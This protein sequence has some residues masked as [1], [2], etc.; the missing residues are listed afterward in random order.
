MLYQ[1]FQT[2]TDLMWP[3][4]TAAKA[5]VPA[6]NEVRR[7]L[8]DWLPVRKAAAAVEV[9]AL[10]QLTHRRPA[11]GITSVRVGRE[12]VPVREE[13]FH[14]TPFGTLLHFRKDTKAAQP[15]VLLA[16]ADVGPL[17]DAAPR[18][19]PHDARGPRRLHHRLAQ[20]ARRAARRRAVRPRRVRRARHE[21]PGGDRA[22]RAPDGDLPAVR[23]GARRRR[24]D[25]RG[26][27]SGDAAEPHPDGGPDRLPDQ[28]DRGEPAR[29]L[30]ADRV[31]R[32]QP[33][34][35]RA[36]ALPGRAAAGLS[37]LRAA[38]R[39]HEHE[40]RAAHRL[41]PRRCSRTW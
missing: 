17:R 24:A 27:P 26:R 2:H 4:R 15:R 23:R 29:D 35:G 21:V 37:G 40:P 16:R 38:Q 41:V 19:R 12:D 18:H 5:A 8:F 28:P 34:R 30:E 25:G 3:P 9:F 22:G 36:G 6:L 10:A 33:D 7:A 31:V 13:I 39:V 1:A 20:R 11:F 14:R 32:A